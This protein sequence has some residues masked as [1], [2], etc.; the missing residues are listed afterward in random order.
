ME[1]VVVKVKNC[2][3]CAVFREVLLTYKHNGEEPLCK[4]WELELQP[5]RETEPPLNLGKFPGEGKDYWDVTAKLDITD[6]ATATVCNKVSP[7]FAPL[8]LSDAGKSVTIEL[9][10]KELKLVKASGDK[11]DRVKVEV[12]SNPTRPSAIEFSFVSYI[13]LLNSFPIPLDVA[14]SHQYGSTALLKKEFKGLATGA[15]TK[16]WPVFYNNWNLS[17]D[18]WTIQLRFDLG[19]SFPS[20]VWEASVKASLYPA[21]QGK[22][23][24]CV[25][26]GKDG[27]KMQFATTKSSAEFNTPQGYL[28]TAFGAVK[29]N[30]KTTIRKMYVQHHCGT[31]QAS[32][33]RY[34]IPVGETSSPFAVE[35]YKLWARATPHCWN[36]TVQLED[37]SF[38]TNTERDQ[39]LYFQPEDS[40][41]L[42]T[43]SV[44]DS[45]FLVR[46]PSNKGFETPMTFVAIAPVNQGR[47]L[48]LPYDKNAFLL[49]H[50]SCTSHSN[51]AKL[52]LQTHNLHA[53]LAH[54]AT[55]LQLELLDG[56][57]D[58]EVS[59]NRLLL[60]QLCYIE[61]F[62]SKN[63]SEV[64]TIFLK[65]NV[66][67]ERQRIQAAFEHAGLWDKIFFCDRETS[68][69]NVS[70]QGWPTLQW[71]IE[72]KKRL[73]V[74]TSSSDGP[75]PNVWEHVSES[76][77]G[78]D[79]IN[80][81]NW[82]SRRFESGELN[83]KP[84]MLLNHSP[85][86]PTTPGKNN[87]NA[88]IQKHFNAIQ[89]HWVQL[90]NFISLQFVEE[91]RLPDGPNT[92]ILAL[93]KK[94]QQYITN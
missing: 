29:N 45:T 78:D 56:S 52:A 55:A 32:Y 75:F 43:F 72:N 64:V 31:Y 70:E 4:T 6:T 57:N 80:E 93:N 86:A 41:A 47:D 90:P 79:S 91:P 24:K 49:S 63:F 2:F 87:S 27:L 19:D 20:P 37:G 3:Q 17:S 14:L 16:P 23:V 18:H 26:D 21:D 28:K 9:S 13:T 5:G 81:S 39:S 88:A 35:F 62:M 61:E 92:A 67:Q 84:L 50:C 25:L 71:M 59:N 66:K 12:I 40:N 54:G 58:V 69:W 89:R 8:L 46:L 11:T 74:F 38:Y 30:F 1:E 73:V 36:I 77:H 33:V 85:N 42:H 7:L 15:L 53:Q 68:G 22:V 82:A 94:L 76:V 10:E 60:D 51:G 34:D 48:A 44:S 83:S 65:D